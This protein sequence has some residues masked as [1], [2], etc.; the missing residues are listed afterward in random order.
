MVVP[1]S[2]CKRKKEVKETKIISA[3]LKHKCISV[4]LRCKVKVHFC[5]GSGFI[6]KKYKIFIFC[7][8]SIAIDCI[9][10]N[11]ENNLGKK[12]LNCKM[13]CLFFTIFFNGRQIA[14][15]VCFP[16]L[17]FSH[18]IPGVVGRGDRIDQHRHSGARSVG[19]VE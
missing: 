13:L 1:V 2:S 14:Y 4:L 3:R 10:I 7:N 9:G 19:Q 12:L 8:K 6:T 17:A 5:I 15:P 16:I 11:N 18:K